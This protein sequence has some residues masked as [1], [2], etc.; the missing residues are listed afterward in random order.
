MNTHSTVLN[1]ARLAVSFPTRLKSNDRR[2]RSSIAQVHYADKIAHGLRLS[3]KNTMAAIVRRGIPHEHR[4]PSLSD[5]IAQ[6]PFYRICA[7]AAVSFLTA[8]PP[9]MHGS[10]PAHSARVLEKLLPWATMAR[11][12]AKSIATRW[13]PKLAANG[14][15]KDGHLLEPSDV[16]CRQ[17]LRHRYPTRQGAGP[18]IC[19]QAR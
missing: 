12:A 4:S 11:P 9:S 19:G 1:D 8:L 18:W 5:I 7:P 15:I 17:Q 13:A 6:C 10:P 14:K 3:R 2:C 16:R